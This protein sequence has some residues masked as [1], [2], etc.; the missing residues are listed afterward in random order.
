MKTRIQVTIGYNVYLVETTHEQTI[1][2]IVNELK[3][4]IAQIKL[5]EDNK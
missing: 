4:V 1:T 2:M 5:I 3:N